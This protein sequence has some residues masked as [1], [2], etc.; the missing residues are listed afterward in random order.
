MP[1]VGSVGENVTV[2]DNNA[3]PALDKV[4][5]GSVGGTVDIGGRDLKQVPSDFVD[6]AGG[7]VTIAIGDGE[8]EKEEEDGDAVGETNFTG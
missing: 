4:K 8:D 2:I 3:M 7:D 5:F 1:N 6:T